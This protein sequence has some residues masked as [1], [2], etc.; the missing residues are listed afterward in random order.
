M[1]LSTTAHI[2][3]KDDKNETRDTENLI[4]TRQPPNIIAS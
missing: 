2:R 1:Y 4:P 3:A